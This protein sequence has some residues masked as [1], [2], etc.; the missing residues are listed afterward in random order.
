M[1]RIGRTFVR[2]LTRYYAAF[3]L[4]LSYSGARAPIEANNHC[5]FFKKV[6]E[7]NNEKDDANPLNP[8]DAA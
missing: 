5:R 3:S 1:G 7:D 6:M 2:Q 8:A 4:L